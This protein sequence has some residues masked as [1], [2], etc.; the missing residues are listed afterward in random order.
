MSLSRRR[1]L[2]AAAPALI[3][4]TTKGDRPIAGGFVLDSF[5]AGH[6]IRDR[7]HFQVPARREKISIAIVGAGMAG[8]SAGW[9]LARRGFHDF[10]ILEMEPSAGGN[11]R[12][13]ENEI[14]A[15]PWAAHYVPVPDA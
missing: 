10:V 13:G 7:A 8:L 5:P 12:W 15:Y 2:R 11:S 9:R 1:F 4:L 3:G 14:T 6:R